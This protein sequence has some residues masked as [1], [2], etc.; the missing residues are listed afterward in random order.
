MINREMRTALLRTYGGIDEYGQ[1]LSFLLDETIIETTFGIYNHQST[2][3]IR[4]QNITHYALTKAPANDKQ[5]LVIDGVEYK[6]MFVNPTG[7]LN[8]LF[9]CQQKDQID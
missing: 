3:D 6:I 4:F 9:L 5:K 1:P 2:N 7:R 8:Q